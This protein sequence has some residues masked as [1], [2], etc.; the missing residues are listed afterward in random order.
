MLVDLNCFSRFLLALCCVIG[1]GAC[2]TLGPEY[3]KPQVEWL[4]K[5]Q[6]DFY[7]QLDVDE[8]GSELDLRF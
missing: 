3:Q 2:T 1:L 5:W 4:N 7:G 6:P 8:T